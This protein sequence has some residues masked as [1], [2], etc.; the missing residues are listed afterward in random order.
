MKLRLRENSIRL[1]VNRQELNRLASG[2]G[3]KE[4]VV[5]PGNTKLSYLLAPASQP[6]PIV[7]FDGSGIRVSVPSRTVKQWADSQDIGIYLDFPAGDA[8]LKVA[9]EKDL[10]CLHGPEEERDPDAFPRN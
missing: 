4:S 2:K 3:L 9:I 6:E 7:L 10:E 1:R 8:L 5:F